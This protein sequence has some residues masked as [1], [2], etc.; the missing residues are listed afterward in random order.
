MLYLAEV[1]KQVRGFLPRNF[2]TEI[3]L[4]AW[5]HNDQTWSSVQGDEVISSSEV[6]EAGAGS[7]FLV[8]LSQNRQIEEP[9]EFAG[10]ELV[11]QLQKLSRLSEKLKDQRQEIEQWKQSL[12]YQS[13]ELSR[14]SM[15]VESRLEIYERNREQIET[16]EQ[17]RQELEK[18]WS[19]LK[20]DQAQYKAEG[21]EI[22]SSISKFQP[23]QI[24]KVQQILA[25]IEQA[26]GSTES[27]EAP[28]NR[29]WEILQT[30]QSALEKYSHQT[31]HKLAKQKQAEQEIANQAE[32]LSLRRREFEEARLALEQIKI[33]CQ[34]EQITLVTKQ[35]LSRRLDQQ[36]QSLEDL[37]VT[38]SRLGLDPGGEIVEIEIDFDSLENMPLAELRESTTQR[39]KD[40]AKLVQFVNDQ[41]E[42]LALQTKTVQDLESKLSQASEYDHISLESALTEEKEKQSMLNETLLG[43]RRNLRERQKILQEYVR[44]LQRREGT[45]DLE[46]VAEINI[47][48]LVQP[49]EN[50]KSQIEAERE[51][52]HSEIEHLE[53]SLAEVS[54]VIEKQETEQQQRAQ[55]LQSQEE[56][57][58]QARAELRQSQEQMSFLEETL[59]PF[60]ARWEEMEQCLH[61]LKQWFS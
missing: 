47:D 16:L 45:F 42:E 19:Q 43:Q 34:S 11:R 12:T 46:Q 48:V 6:P 30:Y 54:S 55:E 2:K 50:W 31:E 1:V 57:W 5:Q 27:L 52:L 25:Q 9:P 38:A 36:L 53:K 58:H 49:L 21:G 41:E 59:Q 15:E 24:E 39:Q 26:G 60:Q 18:G 23:E 14:R 10:P 13:E 40:L 3:R 37:R 22:F 56:S 20:Q 4:L 28:V 33:Q 51:H 35:E 29:L 7:L 8:K 17:Q 32:I 44:V 61:K